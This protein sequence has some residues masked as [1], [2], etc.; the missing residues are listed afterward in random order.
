[1]NVRLCIE[2]ITTWDELSPLAEK[3]HERIQFW[4]AELNKHTREEKITEITRWLLRTDV[5][6]ASREALRKHLHEISSNGAPEGEPQAR[7]DD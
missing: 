4:T 7:Q 6:P 2:M 5:P 1:M 3:R